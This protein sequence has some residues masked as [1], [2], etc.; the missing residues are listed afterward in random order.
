MNLFIGCSARGD[1]NDKIIK[2]CQLLIKD[3]AS[4]D[5]VDLV[6]GACNRGLMKI[7]YEE[8]NKNKKKIIGSSP[9]VYKKEFDGLELD[10][11]I[12]TDTTMERFNI[13]YQK[14]DVFLFLAGGIGTYA[15]L[16][17]T[18]EENRTNKD[19]KTIIIYN[20]DYFYTPIIKDLYRLYQENFIEDK[21]TDYF[22]IESEKENIIKLIKEK[23]K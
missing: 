21:L 15:E 12:V 17:N 11:I 5:K 7:C 16:F 22:I 23:I 10:E 13:L 19:N 14:S 1:I 9:N 3:V 4:I 18:I 8:F 6:F 2:D 20:G